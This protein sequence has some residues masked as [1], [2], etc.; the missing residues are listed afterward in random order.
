MRILAITL[1]LT[2]AAC[3]S[4]ENRTE[5]SSGVGFSNI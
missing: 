5:R 3:A 2:L 1:I 4:V